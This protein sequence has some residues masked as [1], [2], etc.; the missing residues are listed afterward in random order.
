MVRS[1]KMGKGGAEYLDPFIYWADRLSREAGA[2]NINP[3]L[4]GRSL[5]IGGIECRMHGDKGPHGARGSVRNLSRLGVRVVSGHG[6]APAIEEGH[7]RTGTMTYLNL[8]Y[9]GGPSGWLNTHASID[10]FGKPHLHHMIDGKFTT[11]R[12]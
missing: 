8:E 2:S 12:K 6:H 9:N 10:A 4:R 3:I 7:T 11:R 5:L 1:A